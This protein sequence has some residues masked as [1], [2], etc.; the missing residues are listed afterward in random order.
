MYLMELDEG[1]PQPR[2][3]NGEIVVSGVSGTVQ[4]GTEV[5]RFSNL[6]RI[7]VSA[8]TTDIRGR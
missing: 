4:I 5:I 2:L 1:S 8:G 6:E 7:T 3:E